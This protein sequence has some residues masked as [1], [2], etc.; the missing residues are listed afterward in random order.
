MTYHLFIYLIWKAVKKDKTWTWSPRRK[1]S[2]AVKKYLFIIPKILLD[3]RIFSY[4]CWT[5]YVDWGKIVKR[6]CTQKKTYQTFLHLYLCF[7][8]VELHSKIHHLSVYPFVVFFKMKIFSFHSWES[9]KKIDS[10][11]CKS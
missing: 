6:G 2:N 3:S 10:R 7:V 8:L 4:A 9:W 5:T 1:F 11:L